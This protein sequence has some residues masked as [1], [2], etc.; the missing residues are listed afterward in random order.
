MNRIH[1]NRIARQVSVLFYAIVLSA[2]VYFIGTFAAYVFIPGMMVVW[3]LAIIYILYYGIGARFVHIDVRDSELL[4]KRGII[5]VHNTT[6]PFGS[7]TESAYN[8]SMLM[9]L[10]GVGTLEIHT[11]SNHKIHIPNLPY[12]EVQGVL[13]IM[14]KS[15]GGN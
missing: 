1:P 3:G 11:G 4:Y 10:L 15:R 6:I 9:R 12:K 2:V 7:I 13:Q 5:N 8:Q 14:A